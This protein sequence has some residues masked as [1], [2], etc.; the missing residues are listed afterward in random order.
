M[1]NISF[2]SKN[3]F[4]ININNEEWQHALHESDYMLLKSVDAI[5]LEK[6][7]ARNDLLK[8]SVKVELNQ[9]NQLQQILAELFRKIMQVLKN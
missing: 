9:W 4:Y 5:T 8:L 2:F 1:K 3:D 7:F 6:D